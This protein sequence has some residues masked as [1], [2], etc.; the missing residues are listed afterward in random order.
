MQSLRSVLSRKLEKILA[1][2]ITGLFPQNFISKK[3]VS[4]VVSL[5]RQ[6]E[7]DYLLL[8]EKEH[9]ICL[10]SYSVA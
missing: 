3:G 8:G 6:S 7:S 4:K 9:S 1:V 5:V 2:H 10:H